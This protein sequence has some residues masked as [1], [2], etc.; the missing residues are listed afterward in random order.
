MHIDVYMWV[1]LRMAEGKVSPWIG[2]SLDCHGK[3][4]YIYMLLW[5]HLLNSLGESFP[6]SIDTNH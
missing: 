1:L 4:D 6:P 3:C 5:I 2:F